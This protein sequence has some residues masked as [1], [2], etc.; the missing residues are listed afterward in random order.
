MKPQ[1]PRSRQETREQQAEEMNHAA[2]LETRAATEFGSAEELLRHDR[3]QTPVPESVAQRVSESLH[4]QPS[5]PT[6][7]WRRWI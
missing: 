5:A 2:A 6:P 3:A 1:D 7:W 4:R